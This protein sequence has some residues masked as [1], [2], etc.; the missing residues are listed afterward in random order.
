MTTL[1]KIHIQNIN[2]N[3]GSSAMSGALMAALSANIS[4][5]KAEAPISKRPNIGEYW[6]GQGGI[7]V[8]RGRGRDGGRDYSLI[9]PTDKS[10]VFEKRSLGTYGTDVTGATS[11]HDGLANTIAL[12]D[13]GSDLCKEA[14]A[15][16]IDGHK[17]FHVPSRMDLRLMWANVPELFEKEWYLSS[18]Q[19]SSNG[20]W[21]QRFGNGH[22]TSHNKNFE[23]RVRF[24]RRSFL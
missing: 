11:E 19:H 22:S 14:L 9:L 5:T 17:D 18:T 10:C 20:A 15:I 4:T 16:E 23:A 6:Q 24:C 7:Y 12:A 2:L 21:T 3:L 8:G 1:T 13:A